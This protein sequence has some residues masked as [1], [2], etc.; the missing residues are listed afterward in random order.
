MNMHIL[1][2]GLVL[3]RHFFFFF[4]RIYFTPYVIVFLITLPQELEFFWIVLFIVLDAMV[5][6]IQ[7]RINCIRNTHST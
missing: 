5:N 2:G 3:S 4:W 1:T 6:V 7:S